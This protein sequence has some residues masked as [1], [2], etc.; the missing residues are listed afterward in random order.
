MALGMPTVAALAQGVDVVS[1]AATTNVAQGTNSATVTTTNIRGTTAYNEFSSFNIGTGQTV[2]VIQPKGSDAL[3]NIINGGLSR[4]D[5]TLNAKFE[6]NSGIKVGGNHYYV[7][8]DGFV[9]GAAGVINAGALT[10]S[11]PT[12]TVQ[13]N[14]LD[15][16]RNGGSSTTAKLFAGQEGLNGDAGIEIY[17]QVN[18]RRLDLRAGARMLLDGKIT[19]E[20]K[21]SSATGRLTP[22]VNSSGIAKAAG[23]DTSGG[24]V[25]LFSKGDMTIRGDVSARRK[26]AG[27]VVAGETEGEL[28]VG[29]TI[30]VTAAPGSGN[31]S[32][33]VILFTQKSAKFEDAAR[34]LASSIAGQGGLVS[35]TSR[36][37][38]FLRGNLNTDGAG[39]TLRGSVVATAPEMTLFGQVNT[40]GG[41]LVLNVDPDFASDLWKET[42]EDTLGFITVR[43]AINTVNEASTHAG[44]VV[45]MGRDIS[46]NST[47]I[48]AVSNSDDSSS[49]GLVA[50]LSK[51]VD[52]SENYF[53]E[54][55]DVAAQV[56]ITGSTL[57]GGAIIVNSMALTRKTIDDTFTEAEALL[58]IEQA[59]GTQAINETI[60]DSLASA[61]GD[62]M[63][64]TNTIISDGAVT[65]RD[66]VLGVLQVFNINT[67]DASAKV[68][69]TGSTLDSTGNWEG[70]PVT[71]PTDP[72]TLADN[73]LLGADGLATVPFATAEK[74]P[75][76]PVFALPKGFNRSN[77]TYVQ[78]HAA[79]VVRMSGTPAL[80]GLNVVAT[81]TESLVDIQKSGILSEKDVSIYS[82][83]FEDHLIHMTPLAVP[84]VSLG[85]IVAVRNLTNQ[86]VLKNVNASSKGGNVKVAALTGKS[87]DHLIFANAGQEGIFA[88]GIDIGISNGLTEVA[89]GA[90][91]SIGAKGNID[92]NAETLWFAKRSDTTATLGLLNLLSPFAPFRD[93]VTPY[94]E[95][96]KNAYRARF[97]APTV[98]PEPK[99]S[100][101]MGL[102]FVLQIDN[103][104]TRATLGGAY[105]DLAKLEG[106][107][108][109]GLVDIGAASATTL[110]GTVTVEAERRFARVD[111]GGRGF[112]RTAVAETQRITAAV[113][114][115]AKVLKK[116]EEEIT[117]DFENI[118]M[119][120]G[121]ASFF[122]GDTTAEIGKGAKVQAKDLTV[123]AHTGGEIVDPLQQALS[124]LGTIV[125]NT[126][127]VFSPGQFGEETSSSTALG[128]IVNALNPLE[129]VST[130]SSSRGVAAT[131]EER[132]D[133]G[134]TQA[135]ALGITASV[136]NNQAT[137]TAAVRNGARIELTGNAEVTA[138]ASGDFL[139]WANRPF[140]LPGST[141][142]VNDNIGGALHLARLSNTTTAVIEDNA[143]LSTE[144]TVAV[145]AKTELLQ[146]MFTYAGGGAEK[147][148]INAAAGF[149]I[150]DNT[151]IARV[152]GASELRGGAI[153]IE[154]LD[155]S[156]NIGIA[157]A[158]SGADNLSVGAS[159]VVNFAT[160]TVWAGIGAGPAEG[161]ALPGDA[162]TTAVR[163][164][165]LKINA[166]NAAMDVGVAIAGSKTG[167]SDSEADGGETDASLTDS[168]LTEEESAKLAE[169]DD[170]EAPKDEKSVNKPRR[171]WAISG[172]VALNL[173][174]GNSTVAAVD[175]ASQVKVTDDGAFSLT[176]LNSGVTAAATGA[177]AIGFS[178]TQDVNAI[179]GSVSILVDRRIVA[180]RLKST[181]LSAGS[182]ELSASDT[183]LVAN[184]AV[185]GAGTKR[186]SKAIA[187]SV[188]LA[189]LEGM[190]EVEVDAA[191]VTADGL[192]ALATDDSLTVGIGGAAGLNFA[193]NSGMGVGIGISA[194]TILKP[195]TVKILPSSRMS[196][197]TAA[198]GAATSSR[199]YG[200]G[201]S[202]GVGRTA[203][204]GSLTINTIK[205]PAKVEMGATSGGRLYFQSNDTVLAVKETSEILGAAGALALSGNAKTA[206]GGSIV[207]NTIANDSRLDVIKTD[208]VRNGSGNRA[209]VTATA[210]A[211]TE[212]RG[213]AV[214]ATQASSQSIAGG[215]VSNVID[216]TLNV[217]MLR[218]KITAGRFVDISVTNDR[219]LQSLAGGV[220]I[221]GK[222][223]GGGAATLNLILGDEAVIDLSH[224]TFITNADRGIQAKASSTAEILSAAA[225][226]AVSGKT[227]MAPSAT[228][229]V[230][231][232]S[233]GVRATDAEIDARKAG[234]VQ[235]SASDTST[236]RSLAG[237]AALSSGGTGAGAAVAINSLARDTALVL[238]GGVVKAGGA[239]SF[240]VVSDARI[241]SLAVGLAGSSTTGL[242]GSIAIG[243]IGND[244]IV[245]LD[246]KKLKADKALTITAAN[247]SDIRILS[248]AAVVGGDNAVGGAITV[249]SMHNQ[250]AADLNVPNFGSGG[251]VTLSATD[252][253]TIAAKALGGAAAGQSAIS[254]S[255][256]AANIGTVPSD[257]DD[258]PASAPE[259]EGDLTGDATPVAAGQSEGETAKAAA[260][261][262]AA[263]S[264]SDTELEE[265]TL[266]GNIRDRDDVVRAEMAVTQGR[267]NRGAI[268]IM[269]TRNADISTVAG[270]IGLGGENGGGA[271]LGLNLLFGQTKAG[272]YLPGSDKKHNTPSINV[273]AVENDTIDTVAI[274]GGG[275][276]TTGG[277]GGLL[278]N[279][280]SRDIEAEF[281]SDQTGRR[282]TVRLP[283]GKEL[284]VTAEA[285]A[286]VQATAG[287]VGGGGTT[288]VG[289]GVAVTVISDDVT[290]AMR[291]VDADGTRRNGSGQK[292]SGDRTRAKIAA[293][294]NVSV[295][296]AVA[297]VGAGGTTG[298]TGSFGIAVIAGTTRSVADFLA[299]DMQAI[300]ITSTDVQALDNVAGAVAGAGTAAVGVGIVVSTN[301][302][303]NIADVI[304]SRLVAFD[305]MDIHA[306]TTATF[307]GVAVAGGAAGTAAVMGSASTNKMVGTTRTTIKDS[308]LASR[309]FIRIASAA[310]TLISLDGGANGNEGAAFNGAIAI[311]GKVGVGASVTVT[312]TAS[313]NEV[314]INNSNI[315]ALGLGLTTGSIF[316]DGDQHS[317]VMIEADVVT[318]SDVITA[319]GG[320]GFFAG[321]GAAYIYTSLEDAA[322]VLIGN[323]KDIVNLGVEVDG[324][325]L[326]FLDFDTK[327]KSGATHVGAYVDATVKNGGYGVGAG[328]GSGGIVVATNFIA[329]EAA[330][331]LSRSS[332]LA[333]RGAV[334]LLTDVKTSLDSETVGVAVGA[335]AAGGAVAVSEVDTASVIA[336][337][338]TTVTSRASDR[339]VTMDALTSTNV[340]STGGTGSAGGVAGSGVVVVTTLGGQ[341]KVNLDR[342]DD[343]ATTVTSARD[344]GI[345]AKSD[346]TLDTT[347]VG[348]AVGASGALALSANVTKLEGQTGVYLGKFNTL[349]ANR[350][351]SM[352]SRAVRS[353]TGLSGVGA[354]GLVAAGGALDYMSMTEESTVFIDRLAK[355]KADRDVRIV[356]RGEER[357]SSRAVS[358]AA[359]GI[360]TLNGA[361]TILD[362]G[363]KA[364]REGDEDALIASATTEAKTDRSETG[365][366]AKE[367]GDPRNETGTSQKNS[368]ANL[369]S[370]AGGDDARARANAIRAGADIDDAPDSHGGKVAIDRKVEIDAGGDIDIVAGTGTSVSQLAGA[371]GIAGLAS[372]STGTAVSTIAADALVS[373]GRES[374]LRSDGVL[375]IDARTDGL[376]P[377]LSADPIPD[378]GRT[379]I[380]AEAYTGGVSG[381]V[382]L[383]AGVVVAKSEGD[384]KVDIAM[385]ANL[386]GREQSDGTV[387]G[388]DGV[389]VNASR[390]GV[391]RADVFNLNISFGLSA[392]IAVS[393]ARVVGRSAI[394]FSDAGS[395]AIGQT[396]SDGRI[397]LSA[398]DET[399]AV[400]E[401]EGSAGGVFSGNGVDVRTSNVGTTVINLGQHAISSQ[402]RVAIDATSSAFTASHAKGVNAGVAAIGASVARATT[403]A[404]VK[405]ETR[406]VVSASDDVRINATFETRSA[407]TGE[408]R[409]DLTNAYAQATSG[410]GGLLVGNGADAQA[411]I[412][413][414]IDV[415][416]SGL[417]S[418]GNDLVIAGE[419]DATVESDASGK[420]GGLAAIGVVLSDAVVS[421][422]YVRVRSPGALL[423]L[424]NDD[425]IFGAVNE[426]TITSRA[427]SGSGGLISG[428][429]SRADSKVNLETIVNTGSILI[430]AP[431]VRVLAVNGPEFAGSLDNVRAAAVGMSGANM[432]TDVT[433]DVLLRIGRGSTIFGSEISVLAQNNVSRPEDGFNIESGSGGLLD[434]AAMKSRFKA[435]L[436]QLID[437]QNNTN[438]VQT[439]TFG[440]SGRFLIALESNVQ[441]VDRQDLDSGGAIPI[442]A[443]ESTVE[444]TSDQSEIE[445]GSADMV[446]LNDLELRVGG[447]ADLRSEVFT[448]SYGLAGA[449]TAKALAS[450][451]MD[452]KITLKSG[453]SLVS[454]ENIALLIGRGFE[455]V[456]DVKIT[457]EARAFNRTA[458]P[459]STNPVGTASANTTATIA[460]G[461]GVQIRA[462]GDVALETVDGRREL[463]GYG[464][465]KDLYQEVAAEIA[466]VFTSDENGDPI[467]IESEIFDVTDRNLRTIKL[468]GLVRAGSRNRRALVLDTNGDLANDLFG[469]DDELAE[470]I[471]FTVTEGVQLEFALQDR[472]DEIDIL[473]A[474]PDLGGIAR[475][476]LSAERNNLIERRSRA[477][478]VIAPRIE[479][480]NLRAR[481]GNISLLADVVLG[482]D[483]GSLVAPGDA[484]IDIRVL[485]DAF[486]VIND[487]FISPEDGGIVTFNDVRVAN[488]QDIRDEAL[489][490]DDFNIEVLALAADVQGFGVSSALTDEKPQINVSTIG[491]NSNITI[492]GHVQNIRGTARLVANNASLEIRGAVSALTP[493]LAAPNGDFI[494]NSREA[495]NHVGAAPEGRYR[496]Y[497]SSVRAQMRAIIGTGDAFNVFANSSRITYLNF[498]GSQGFSENIDAGTFDVI[499]SGDPAAD[500]GI[501]RGQNVFI[502]ADT[503][504][505]TGTIQAGTVGQQVRINAAIDGEIDG[506]TRGASS[507]VELFRPV[508]PGDI[509]PDNSPHIASTVPVYYDFDTDRI[510]I[511]DAVAE[512]GFVDIIGKIVST[513]QGRIETLDGFGAVVIDSNSTRTV[514]LGRIDTGTSETSGRGI[515]GLVRIT[516]LNRPI[517]GDKFLITEFRRGRNP[518]GTPVVTVV[519]NRS[520]VIKVDGNGNFREIPINV[521]SSTA[522]T[523]TATYTPIDD[524]VYAQFRGEAV[525]KANG[526]V[527][528]LYDV[529]TFMD[530][531]FTTSS[532]FAVLTTVSNYFENGSSVGDQIDFQ[533]FINASRPIEV[534]F[535]GLDAGLLDIDVEGGLVLTDLVIN[536][537]GSSSIVADGGPVLAASNLVSINTG[538]LAL[539]SNGGSVSGMDGSALRLAMTPG[540]TLSVLGDQLVNLYETSG[541]IQIKLAFV[542][543]SSI[544]GE[545]FGK[546]KLRARGS[547]L[548]APGGN[549]IVAGGEVELIAETGS[550]SGA[551][552]LPVF[553]SE[554]LTA[555]ARGNVLISTETD[556]PVRSVTSQTGSVLLRTTDGAI[557][558]A[559]PV[560]REDIRTRDQLVNLWTTDLGLVSGSAGLAARIDA[561]VDALRAQEV[562][563]YRKYWG[564]RSR[565]EANGGTDLPVFALDPEVEAALLAQ[566]NGQETVERLIAEGQARFAAWNSDQSFDAD[567]QPQLLTS[568]QIAAAVEGAG[569]TLDELERSIN[570]GIVRRSA[571]TQVRDEDAN[572]I[573]PGDIFLTATDGIGEATADRVL[574]DGTDR[575]LDADDLVA[576]AAAEFG[577]VTINGDIVTVA[578][579]DDLNLL[580]TQIDSDGRAVGEVD[581]IT[582]FGDLLIGARSA[583][584][585][586]RAASQE[587][588]VIKT[589]GHL[590]QGSRSDL[591]Q[592][593]IAGERIIL[594]AGRGGDIGGASGFVLVN[595]LDGG[596]LNARAGGG[597]SISAP[598]SDLPLTGIFSPSFVSLSSGGSITDVIA[599]GESRVIGLTLQLNSAG[600]IGS[601][602]APLLTETGPFGAMG[603]NSGGNVFLSE[604]NDLFLVRAEIERGGSIAT[605][606]RFTL[607]HFDGDTGRIDFGANSALTI[608]ATDGLFA[609]RPS[610]YDIAGGAVNVRTGG[611][612][613][614]KSKGHLEVE[615]G[616]FNVR[617]IDDAATPVS[618]FDPDNLQV[619]VVDLNDNA[620]STL[621]LIA[622]GNLNFFGVSAHAPVELISQ[623]GSILFGDV[624]APQVTM[625]SA[626]G[627]GTQQQVTVTTDRLT[628]YSFGGNVSV[629]V[630]GGFSGDVVEVNYMAASGDTGL[631]LTSLASQLVLPGNAQL[632]ALTGDVTVMT[633]GALSMSRFATG[634]TAVEGKV[635]I[636][637]L[638]DLTLG[639]IRSGS[640]ASDAIKVLS[641]SSAISQV[642]DLSTPMLTAQA[643]GAGVIVAANEIAT[644]LNTR[645]LSL[646]ISATNG[647]IF[648]AND[649]AM[650]LAGL[651]GS[652]GATVTAEGAMTIGDINMSGTGLVSLIAQTFLGGAGQVHAG[653]LSINATTGAIG[654]N[655]PVSLTMTSSTDLL[656][657]AAG[658]IDL[659]VTG[660]DLSF[661]ALDAGGDVKLSALTGKIIGERI[662]ADTVTLFAATGIGS[663]GQ[664]VGIDARRFSATTA[665]G[666]IFLKALQADAFADVIEAGGTGGVTLTSDGKVTLAANGRLQALS[667]NIVINVNSLQ[668]TAPIFTQTG[669]VDITADQ[670]LAMAGGR[671]SVASVLGRV[672][673]RTQGN[674]VLSAVA[675]LSTAD[676]AVVISADGAFSL[677][678][679]ETR[680]RLTSEG[681]LSLTA[682]SL[683]SDIGTMETQIR[684]LTTN[685]GGGTLSLDNIGAGIRLSNVVVTN[686]NV[687]VLTS[688]TMTLGSVQTLGTITLAGVQIQADQATLLAGEVTLNAQGAG[689]GGETGPTMNLTL[690]LGSVLNLSAVASISVNVVSGDVTVGQ[691]TSE[692][693][694]VDLTG[695][696]TITLSGPVQADAAQTVKVTA[697]GAI[698]SE[699]VVDV[700][701]QRASFIANGG[702]VQG[703]SGGA[704]TAD[705][706]DGTTVDID[707][708]G[709]IDFAEQVGNL[710]IGLIDAN[711]LAQIEALDGAILAG[712]SNAAATL[713][714]AKS[715][716]GTEKAFILNAGIVRALSDAG[717]V[718]LGFET[719][720]LAM[721]D[722]VSTTGTGRIELI[723]GSRDL[724][725]AGESVV[726]E[727]GDIRIEANNFSLATQVQSVSGD[728][729]VILS[730]NLTFENGF[731][732]ILSDTGNVDIV[733]DLPPAKSLTVM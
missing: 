378:D 450:Y 623:S 677:A 399:G 149:G 6:N 707:T 596:S 626:S 696:G 607:S 57:D 478:G 132:P 233:T 43:E 412:N 72:V 548:E 131:A 112:Q 635:N 166:N 147:R 18:A 409:R 414:G 642:A 393:K 224:A 669:N 211:T 705:T 437:I 523:R 260:R 174:L 242:A 590:V 59:G 1:G 167:N 487:L 67:S 438:L 435:K 12:D 308:I 36:E 344:I 616:V 555:S 630:N 547:I 502:N 206:A 465:G 639:T 505:I 431:S 634:I 528:L 533:Q 428:A 26:D 654:D 564:A 469:Y 369:A 699:G 89:I 152:G 532:D 299:L 585:V 365:R 648:V 517:A 266:F 713:L 118:L 466:N 285:K 373:I 353:L 461:N 9:V 245:D 185:G 573:A 729:D 44:D 287:V 161:A 158:I 347:A 693:G 495:F 92:V 534:V 169:H 389:Q 170:E 382:A 647:S 331:A 163:G 510:V 530:S 586:K 599:N 485:Q 646:D 709:E 202:V 25:R 595:V 407:G 603:I 385:D 456:Q 588:T 433:S 60:L 371:G 685:I 213:Y 117:N 302:A 16:A 657:N 384:A 142:P 127:N 186:G 451:Q 402:E 336:L 145:R 538:D 78:S 633:L 295:D 228:A 333:Q 263:Q 560:E 217:S 236:I 434:E 107:P 604:A 459:I 554:G 689:I 468:D 196:V 197:K 17:G 83:A 724:S 716:I 668:V 403:T 237:G 419:S 94:V 376:D 332:I 282:A 48:E 11:T 274:A 552:H 638:G 148:A 278:I 730:G 248:G 157:G 357:A 671:G 470:N 439:A 162:S 563:E 551:P 527:K 120:S 62:G 55:N 625:R 441:V 697:G 126:G 710:R 535:N 620:G 38:I 172:A 662:N 294:R 400:A 377:L 35:V 199:I 150:M 27:G 140:V 476:R 154:A 618:V 394:T 570:S 234:V 181:D 406:G 328:L 575:D 198:I 656:L 717:N 241:R 526:N 521:V 525:L 637:A 249:A 561:Q 115:A 632:T 390:S 34:I 368:A 410:A 100:S 151:T 207:I 70:D 312:D 301:S 311:G 359:S 268:D 286:D 481:E 14:L 119:L 614:G 429:A 77:G 160:R 292:V 13:D 404:D 93:K 722:G 10:L 507:R 64:A 81:K 449:A 240:A 232:G 85:V 327:Q 51:H 511:D 732:Q 704:F 45:I 682:S 343:F 339:D 24:V 306:K 317:G 221:S 171:G 471:D 678:G 165:S 262:F 227:G 475:A 397:A 546:L 416:V 53:V 256:V 702:G 80:V 600:S 598:D 52:D 386:T 209:K 184:I 593:R 580:A 711:G 97:T 200:F 715:G 190:T 650:I 179:A 110:A 670:R 265:G 229:N 304:N 422:G 255:I 74:N 275:G 223:G 381:V 210:L 540:A 65:G 672:A 640:G 103:D 113:K 513:G 375:S 531:P 463:T 613:T 129:L 396:L 719:D 116:T 310:K 350:D 269:A 238:R 442:P 356:A 484:L 351:I 503:V 3:V 121:S 141:E 226:I 387:L 522:N 558:D 628:A 270:A 494:L 579:R 658:D 443:G 706:G 432:L 144:G 203:I 146:G 153:T 608:V 281:A 421:R 135:F 192:S 346:T 426:P 106:D 340:K 258:Q 425:L 251:T 323:G 506:L 315:T 452:H 326:E 325:A 250:V 168:V 380:D 337:T 691:A 674:M 649:I 253:G 316:R 88:L 32:G 413:Y 568:D 606:G 90:N 341:T 2:D 305:G 524:Q 183:A 29:G 291:D 279:V 324:R 216:N 545:A 320:A 130:Y 143:R 512:G 636:S 47:Q 40:D 68:T 345:E 212:I 499:N 288:G 20:D 708:L 66:A 576:L 191:E 309:G 700:A 652:G 156:K 694:S 602:F 612:V 239:A 611:T 219:Y 388:N 215:F 479:I 549:V 95:L 565:I 641:T 436:N 619:N 348:G 99:P 367:N 392:G 688:G 497:M 15:E 114:V 723:A 472:I 725:I 379:L 349:N 28:R 362:L 86:V 583:L 556:L 683:A 361:L 408:N 41:H 61:I 457:A 592:N 498:E 91:S 159:G 79:S 624:T 272:L 601:T 401:A 139:H 621:S 617:S 686:G 681:G 246:I 589:Q 108:D 655:A 134:N 58:D 703:A 56:T 444:V 101:G 482:S 659:A 252:T 591:V 582:S 54:A 581:A 597:L 338:G 690:G 577:D 490:R 483:S 293:N 280:I 98:E 514:E 631:T 467:S 643:A 676:E 37:K 102:A 627:V 653:R 544:A 372:A 692:A 473:L 420:Q 667:G 49:D 609:E 137:T 477:A 123:N 276:G 557:R 231:N 261:D 354:A 644:P 440:E 418:T 218:T 666:D 243:D 138:L 520:T 714:L 518:D 550:I 629:G 342:L 427:V 63:D 569:W 75:M 727:A 307:G 500:T 562:A 96:A 39:N 225:G 330:V 176:A 695:A 480:G 175:T 33:S 69:I 504:N 447:N 82:T 460:I 164:T 136:Y 398:S 508:L 235:L 364:S 297:S 462:E 104:D 405:I 536:S 687:D 318:R 319:T 458:I 663:T 180:A 5:G 488:A 125:A 464:Q 610:G 230:A 516:D 594:E 128:N 574:L 155:T 194:N 665:V 423:A 374:H 189:T 622:D 352:R 71:L 572:I 578:Q 329:T 208:I 188:A 448:K 383:G 222:G 87:H 489:R 491:D 370:M 271:A 76:A 529:G 290:A 701:G 257:P 684:R 567:Y 21:R 314:V 73:D 23:I 303:E 300:E 42:N 391:V 537:L 7:N 335:G 615:V 559:N 273:A 731:A 675:S 31:D 363:G 542:E 30:D 454:E 728:I 182:V 254:V 177:G 355:V 22:A 122:A 187:G 289:A 509:V 178:T 493:I 455:D 214:A 283:S 486:V 539:G 543:D 445:I 84:T 566:P 259:L 133:D 46:I 733:T 541:D 360:G 496:D 698:L 726:S 220:G 173:S 50:L 124:G 247:T 474:N 244:T 501:V 720:G 673:L 515:E 204:A 201:I 322:R 105:H 680:T 366:A 267:V 193:T 417:V 313:T 321:V 584:K 651:S 334:S 645:V 111:E 411:D 424:A 519:N 264:L 296:S 718:R 415:T 395:G 492:N 195:A 277:A 298:L 605:D 205:N 679:G 712:F 661:G 430:N 587:L 8:R 553:V 4:I 571:D 453:A 109:A 358:V 446:A 284:S 19:I 664:P 660:A 721:V